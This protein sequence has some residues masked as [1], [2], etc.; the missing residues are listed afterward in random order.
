MQ[1]LPSAHS[2]R[3]RGALVQARVDLARGDFESAE[4]RFADVIDRLRA[5]KAATPSLVSAYRGRA[6]A[7]LRQGDAA[8]ALPDAQAAVDLARTLQGSNAHSD[9]TGLAWLT[10]GRV[11]RASGTADRWPEA[12][13]TAHDELQQTL[14]SDHPETRAAAELLA[15]R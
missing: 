6:E 14:G 15:Q 9:Q 2:A 3:V 13:R 12:L 11:L 8:R 4:R 10:L 7:I 1:S 5:Q